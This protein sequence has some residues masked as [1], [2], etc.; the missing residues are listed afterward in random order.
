MQRHACHG[1]L[2]P[3]G[4][5]KVVIDTEKRKV[6]VA[7]PSVALLYPAVFGGDGVS[8]INRVLVARDFARAGRSGIMSLRVILAWLAKC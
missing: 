1:S 3:A 8:P 7:N 5:R 6:R 4:C 2:W